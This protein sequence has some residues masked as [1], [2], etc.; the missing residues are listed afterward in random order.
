MNLQVSPYLPYEWEEEKDGKLKDQNYD[1]TNAFVVAVGCYHKH[2][3]DQVL[4]NTAKKETFEER[5]K[6]NKQVEEYKKELQRL[7]PNK[8]EYRK[9]V[10]KYEKKISKEMGV[11]YKV[12]V[13][14]LVNSYF[15]KNIFE[16]KAEIANL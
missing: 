7:F 14:R 12:A 9:Q 6:E 15:H 8:T 3:V 5:W 11:A 1:I 16:L 4:S 13:N 10:K 2:L